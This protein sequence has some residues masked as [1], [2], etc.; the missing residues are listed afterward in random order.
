MGKQD[1]NFP[2]LMG[3]VGVI[4]LVLGIAATVWESTSSVYMSARSWVS[5]VMMPIVLGVVLI[6]L[7]QVYNHK[8]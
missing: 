7:R 5:V 4:L 6:V 1:V 8:H 3:I 2:N